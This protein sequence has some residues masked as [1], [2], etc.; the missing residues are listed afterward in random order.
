MHK[1]KVKQTPQPLLQVTTT[2][3]HLLTFQRSS[4]SINNDQK[5]NNPELEKG[6]KRKVLRKRYCNGQ[7]SLIT[8]KNPLSQMKL[9][10]KGS[11]EKDLREK[12]DLDE[13]SQGK[14]QHKSGHQNHHKVIPICISPEI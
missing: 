11:C 7:N 14:L 6:T 3:R 13:E 10:G 9:L 12:P 8:R 4:A 2:P 5:R 1:E